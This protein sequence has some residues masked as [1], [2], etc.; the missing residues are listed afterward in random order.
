MKTKIDY[1]YMTPFYELN[2]VVVFFVR[3]WNRVKHSRIH[4]RGLNKQ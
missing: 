1:Y 3:L 4:K 2:Y